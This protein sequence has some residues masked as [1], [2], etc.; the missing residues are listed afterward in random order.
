MRPRKNA[1]RFSACVVIQ[2]PYVSSQ[3]CQRCPLR[4]LVVFE[5]APV[6]LDKLACGRRTQLQDS[7]HLPDASMDLVDPMAK[8]VGDLL[9]ERVVENPP[10]LGGDN[11]LAVCDL[12]A[13][14]VEDLSE[15]LLGAALGHANE[16]ESVVA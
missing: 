10:F 9:D 5:R 8:V 3:Q 6:E 12:G 13:Q 16:Q 1:I 15:R 7:I 2:V 4:V 14:R 11:L